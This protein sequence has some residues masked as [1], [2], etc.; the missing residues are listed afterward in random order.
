MVDHRGKG[1]ET[2]GSR[3]DSSLGYGNLGLV[4]PGQFGNS[5][6]EPDQAA[7]QRQ[8]LDMY[9]KSMQQFIESLAKLKLPMG[10]DPNPSNAD[11]GNVIR[12]MEKRKK[13]DVES[14][15]DG[16]RIFYCSRAFF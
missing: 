16:S 8:I 14:K 12:V 5:E 7:M 6:L 1:N 11:S 3:A 2:E 9:M 13:L 15:K 10:L 4:F